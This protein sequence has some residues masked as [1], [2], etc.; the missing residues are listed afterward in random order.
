MMIGLD[1]T[2]KAQQ[3]HK[4]QQEQKK[5]PSV[6]ITNIKCCQSSLP[7]F[8][9]TV[10]LSLNENCQPSSDDVESSPAQKSECC[11]CCCCLAFN[12]LSRNSIS[13]QHVFLNN[14]NRR[15][16]RYRAYIYITSLTTDWSKQNRWHWRL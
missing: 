7:I 8:M 2:T 12:S 13:F 10:P 6:V 16:G 9:H 15:T 3:K 1:S 4:S 14:N 5:I 11:F